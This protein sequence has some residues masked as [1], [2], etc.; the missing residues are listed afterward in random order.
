MKFIATR[1]NV[2]GI[3]GVQVT[4]MAKVLGLNLVADQSISKASVSFYSPKT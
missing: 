3:T 2:L 1:E 4:E